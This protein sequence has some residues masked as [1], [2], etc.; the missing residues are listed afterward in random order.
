MYLTEVHGKT[1]ETR[2]SRLHTWEWNFVKEGEKKSRINF[3]FID[4]NGRNGTEEV[5]ARK[6]K[7]M[8]K[9]NYCFGETI[10]E[11][12]NTA[13]SLV[14]SGFITQDEFDVLFA[15]AK[16][17]DPV[18]IIKRA[19]VAA[20]EQ[21]GFDEERDEERFESALI[22]LEKSGFIDAKENPKVAALAR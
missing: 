11:L 21:F 6:F 16:L 22:R 15:N 10:P 8:I 20:K 7:E 19:A 4:Y 13:D 14:E 1:I 17:V 3:N 12:V 18:E 5:F 2:V 9:Y